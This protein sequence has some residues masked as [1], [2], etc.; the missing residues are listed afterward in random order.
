MIQSHIWSNS[1]LICELFNTVLLLVVKYFSMTV[2]QWCSPLS[3]SSGKQTHSIP[4][5]Q[6][7]IMT[8]LDENGVVEAAL[9]VHQ[10]VLLYTKL[11]R[12]LLWH[13]HTFHT[14][15]LRAGVCQHVTGVTA[16]LFWCNKQHPLHVSSMF[17]QMLVILVMGFCCFGLY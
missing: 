15:L 17:K 10:D 1:T 11:L 2:S 12:L 8:E 7:H 3:P 9:S 16:V 13:T 6:E 4:A 14:H 5:Q